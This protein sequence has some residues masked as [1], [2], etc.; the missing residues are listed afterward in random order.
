MRIFD[1]TF[2]KGIYIMG[3]SENEI[4]RFY[5][6]LQKDQT[7]L[8]LDLKNLKEDD[9]SHKVEANLQ[10]QISSINQLMCSLL[11]LKKLKKIKM[12]L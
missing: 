5:D 4:L 11:K 9:D 7:Q 6:D 12:S 1:Y 8:L 2:F 10:K 3:L